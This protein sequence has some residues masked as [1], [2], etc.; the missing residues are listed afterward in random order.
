MKI[1]RMHRGDYGKIKAF[2]DLETTD[3][4]TIKGFKLIEAIDGGLFVGFPSKKED[5][6]EYRDT[7]WADKDLKNE[8]GALAHNEYNN[9]S[10]EPELEVVEK[11][12]KKT[13][14]EVE[15]EPPF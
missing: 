13:V 5:G 7:V 14:V 9:P 1:S 2:F 11:D 8:V 12:N 3:G 6:G 10:P 4:F 15:E